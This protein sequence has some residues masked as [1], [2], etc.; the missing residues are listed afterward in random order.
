MR[1]LYGYVV[2]KNISRPGHF[3]NFSYF[4][5]FL[6]FFLVE[7]RTPLETQKSQK[8]KKKKKKKEKRKKKKEKKNLTFFGEKFGKIF[9]VI[10]KILKYLTNFFF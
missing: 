7:K 9:P 6:S 10:S 2:R 1:F 4:F 5:F 3:Y 8:K